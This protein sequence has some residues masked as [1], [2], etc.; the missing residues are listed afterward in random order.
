VAPLSAEAAAVALASL[1]D[2][3]PSRLRAI[4]QA[5]GFERG[6]HQVLERRLSRHPRVARCL[7]T[8]P[9]RLQRDLAAAAALIDPQARLEA[10]RRAGVQVVLLG[11]DRYPAA[12]AADPEPPAVLFARGDLEVISGRRV[13][14]IGT[15]RCTRSGRLVA[16]E[17]GAQ[18]AE[19]GVGVVS[20]L[21]LGI[22]GAAHEG[23]LGSGVDQPVPVVGVVGSGLDV[24][25]PKRHARLWEAVATRGVLLSEW[26][27][28]CAALAWHFPA[29]NRIIA[30]L[31]E[32]VVVVESHAAGGALHTVEE[33]VRRGRDILV[34]PGSVRSPASA[35]TNALLFDGAAPARDAID[36]L[37]ALGF[38]APAPEQ[39]AMIHTHPEEA[40]ASPVALP[41]RHDLEL[42]DLL[43]GE[44]RTLDQLAASSGRALG[45]LAVA[46]LRFERYGW[47]E[48]SGA[49]IERVGP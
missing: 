9:S 20:G 11:D 39:L 5:F 8:D 15:R 1:P 40:P 30:A 43:G 37:G 16:L 34:V 27:L 23:A 46:L 38:V 17:M 7:G 41:D 31:V 48:R 21:A 35:G 19:A 44:A 12:L 24:V 32:L 3:N 47:I 2:M 45:E 29:R 28:G 36:V 10:H 33:A 4:R 22:D 26:P 6:W 13:A 42:L 18:L 14:V 25:Y 49:W